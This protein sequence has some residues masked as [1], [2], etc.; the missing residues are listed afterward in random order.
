LDDDRL[1]IDHFER[2]ISILENISI[3][4]IDVDNFLK[5]TDL[6]GSGMAISLSISIMEEQVCAA[7]N[8]IIFAYISDTKDFRKVKIMLHALAQ[9]LYKFYKDLKDRSGGIEMYNSLDIFL[10]KSSKQTKPSFL[11]N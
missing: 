8:S 6:D 9:S 2:C 1:N 7:K 3:H 11:V 4:L 5:E 10:L